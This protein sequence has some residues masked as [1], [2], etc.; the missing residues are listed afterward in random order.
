MAEPDLKLQPGQTAVVTIMPGI[1]FKGT[2]TGWRL[3]V[4]CTGDM[5]I[6]PVSRSAVGIGCQNGKAVD[7]FLGIEE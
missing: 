6:A 2:N 1:E 4:S 5:A 3:E 7:E